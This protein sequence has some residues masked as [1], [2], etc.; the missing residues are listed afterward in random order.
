[1][2]THR[3]NNQ[4]TV[5]S[6]LVCVAIQGLRSNQECVS[7]VRVK[8]N[9]KYKNVILSQCKC[10][11]RIKGAIVVFC[12]QNNLLFKPKTNAVKSQ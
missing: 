11:N 12:C 3:V 4:S 10:G 1:M 2:Y 6:K 7:F 8:K 5:N 9:Y